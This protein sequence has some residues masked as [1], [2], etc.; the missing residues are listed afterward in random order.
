MATTQAETVIAALTQA[1][2]SLEFPGGAYLVGSQEGDEPE[3]EVGPFRALTHWQAIEPAFL[4]AQASALSFF[5]EAGFRF[6]LPAYLVADV[7]GQL[8]VADPLFHL[9][10]GFYEIEV[11]APVGT[12]TF[13]LKS[14]KATLINPRRYGAMTAEDYARYRLA[15]F[16]REEA[17]AIV[18]YLHFKRNTDPDGMDKDRINAALETFWLPRSQSAPLT[19]A[20]AQHVTEQDAFVAAIQARAKGN[21]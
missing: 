13:T 17:S 16:T 8:Q 6:F 21:D 1:F 18:A 5:S 10:N 14:G 9:T 11:N 4:D 19:E 20:L 3:Q 15:V 2:A 7:R 12:Q